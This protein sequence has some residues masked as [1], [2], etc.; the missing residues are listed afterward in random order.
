MPA[1][2][3]NLN[4]PVMSIVPDDVSVPDAVKAPDTVNGSPLEPVCWSLAMPLSYEQRCLS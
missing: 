3:S 2:P 1:E 4:P